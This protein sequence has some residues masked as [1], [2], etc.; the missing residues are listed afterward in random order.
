MGVRFFWGRP[1]NFLSD[2]RGA[3]HGGAKRG[4]E[5]DIYAR[6]DLNVLLIEPLAEIFQR[7]QRTIARYPK[8][9]ILHEAKI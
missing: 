8:Q 5:A 1:D 6:H 4:Q 7:L 9:R 3:I 2:I